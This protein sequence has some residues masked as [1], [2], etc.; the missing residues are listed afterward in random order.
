MTLYMSVEVVVVLLPHLLW[1][2]LHISLELIKNLNGADLDT[3]VI[4]LSNEG[5]EN[6]VGSHRRNG[7]YDVKLQSRGVTVSTG[8]KE[9][10]CFRNNVMHD[11]PTHMAIWAET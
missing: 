9:G 2:C 10:I 11:T 8:S 1:P 7:N 4:S 6:V 3:Y 5:R